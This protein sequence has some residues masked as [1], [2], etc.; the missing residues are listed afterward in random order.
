MW[1]GSE[2]QASR[3][4]ALRGGSAQVRPRTRSGLEGKNNA[5]RKRHFRS[6]YAKTCDAAVRF[7]AIEKGKAR[8]CD[9]CDERGGQ[10]K[11]N[12]CSSLRENLS[13]SWREEAVEGSFTAALSSMVSASSRFSFVLEGGTASSAR[14]AGS[15]ANPTSTPSEP[16]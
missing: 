4:A 1:K 9:D 14:T 10:S 8:N 11:L 3:W 13:L 5:D 2:Q 15:P 16:P 6:E 12:H 7:D